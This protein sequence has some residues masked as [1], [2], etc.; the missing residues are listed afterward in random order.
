MQ[1]CDGWQCLLEL[2]AKDTC[3]GRF[4]TFEVFHPHR[5][6]RRDGGAHFDLEIVGE[7]TILVVHFQSTSDLLQLSHGHLMEKC[8]REIRTKRCNNAI[9]NKR[10]AKESFSK[11]TN[12]FPSFLQ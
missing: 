6:P 8:S 5:N 1:V 11:Q 12:L 4:R 9:I 2:H 10:V 7:N 3:S